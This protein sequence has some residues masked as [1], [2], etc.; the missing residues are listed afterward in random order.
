MRNRLTFLIIMSALLT[1]ALILPSWGAGVCDLDADCNIDLNDIN[2]ITAAINTAA[3][4]GDPRDIDKNGRITVLDARKCVVLCTKSRCAIVAPNCVVEDIDHDGFTTAQGDCNDNDPAVYPGAPEVCNGIDDNCIN[5]IDEN[6]GGGACATGL[7]GICSSGVEQCV[8]GQMVCEGTNQPSAETCDGLDNDCDG[9]VDEDMGQTTCGLGA[10]AHTISNCLDGMTQVC[11]PFE[12]AAAEICDSLDNDCDGQ[13]DEGLLNA[14]G[15]C[16]PVPAETCDGADNDCDGETDEGLLNACGACG[17]V[18]AETCDGADNDCD[19]ET[20]EGFDEDH[21]GFRTCAGDCDDGRADVH[22]GVYDIPGNGVD[23]DCSGGDAP[24]PLMPLVVVDKYYEVTEGE[25]L[26]FQVTAYDP[27]GTAVILSAS[28]LIDNAAFAATGGIQASGTF[29]FT[30]DNSQQGKHYIT[31]TATD[32]LGYKGREMVTISVNNLNHAPVIGF[33]PPAPIDEGRALALSLDVTDPDGDMLSVSAAPLPE[34]A[35]FVEA[36]RTLT[37]TPDY[38]QAGEYDITF[39]ADDGGG[40]QTASAHI[41]VNDVQ[42]GGTDGELSL[43]VDPVESPTFGTTQRVTGRVNTEGQAVPAMKYSLLTGLAPASGDQGRTLDVGLTGASSGDYVTHFQGGVSQVNFGKGITVN[44]FSVISPAEAAANITIDGSAETGTRP[45]SVVTGNEQAVS[46]VAFNVTAGS[47]GIGGILVDPDTNQPIA[48]AVIAIQ[49]TT[50]TTTTNADGSFTLN[51]VP[52]GSL[53]LIINAP[54]HEL[55]MLPV[56]AVTGVIDI[57]EIESRA[58]VFDPDEPPSVSIFSVIG[59]GSAGLAPNLNRNDMKQL[60]TDSILLVGGTDAGVLDEF[61]NQ[62]NHQIEGE[63]AISLTAEGVDNLADHMLQGNTATLGET[64]FFMTYS[65]QW[66]GRNYPLTLYEWMTGLQE[67]VNAAWSDPMNPDN[68]PVLMIFN[69][70]NTVL[71]GPPMLSS[72]TR[73]NALQ[74]YLLT[75]SFIAYM[76]SYQTASVTDDQGGGP[77]FASFMSLLSYIGDLIAPS[78]WADTVPSRFTGFWRNFFESKAAWP[79]FIMTTGT[80]EF[81]VNTTDMMWAANAGGIGGSM[82]AL[83]IAGSTAFDLSPYITS[84]GMSDRVPEPPVI[85]SAENESGA[86]KISFRTSSSDSSSTLYFY[87]LFHF[88][89]S[90]ETPRPVSAGFTPF[91]DGDNYVIYDLAPPLTGTGFYSMTVTYSSTYRDMLAQIGYD[92][93][94]MMSWWAMPL[95]GAGYDQIILMQKYGLTSDY[96]NPVLYTAG[97]VPDMGNIDALAVNAASDVYVS[98]PGEALVRTAENKGASLAAPVEAFSTMFMAPAQ[99]G[100]A[101]DSA[102]N[103][104]CDNAASDAE[105]GGRIFR[106]APDGSREFTGS[107][108]YFS[109]MLMFANPVSSGPMAM[110]PDDYLFVYERLSR[111]VRSVDVNATYDPFRRVGQGYIKFT[112]PLVSDIFDIEFAGDS[113]E[114]GG[115]SIYMLDTRG[116]VTVPYSSG[117][118]TSTFDYLQLGNDE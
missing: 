32:P 97:P 33:E 58:T 87:N 21:D 52:A 3:S 110:S 23:E 74:K 29:T 118:G 16:G 116:I 7:P 57:G 67:M 114:G 75:A 1:C 115:S 60:I 59:R 76:K 94:Q 85:L 54:D 8:N 12:G 39:A 82:L 38:E 117:G 30:P 65:F 55:I 84:T 34:N 35:I 4:P 41:T 89:N 98:F 51:D 66:Q 18:P 83:T 44:S 36:T 104:Y 69:Q 63:G 46:I 27:D 112:S 77:L 72:S 49:G 13:T 47:V 93:Q 99:K 48:N 15:A 31:F 17:P 78:A 113:L 90:M 86:V 96:S 64:L 107:L 111:E 88:E 45:V 103:L 43:E 80:S 22:P 92:P 95:S 91:P 10:C 42:G 71:P 81:L 101:I 62:M 6:L 50:I 2:V 37:F 100:L 70:G 14:C 19:G 9:S 26:Q 61:G 5:S 106:F 102:G 108:N 25:M 53:T 79:E 40:P 28:P 24:L 56:E 105:F 109:Q 20:D 11:D 68:Y 73:L